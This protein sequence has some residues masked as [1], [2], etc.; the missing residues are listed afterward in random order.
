MKKLFLTII[1]FASQA[2]A[3]PFWPDEAA[4]ECIDLSGDYQCTIRGMQ[5]P[6][7]VSIQQR[8]D[9][10]R[11]SHLNISITAPLE[12]QMQGFS[13]AYDYVT[14]K[15]LQKHGYIGNCSKDGFAFITPIMGTPLTQIVSYAFDP[16]EKNV[17]IDNRLGIMEEGPE[18][19]IANFQVKKDR[20]R[21]TCIKKP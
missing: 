16:R 9:S 20:G 17:K 8:V 11:R 19:G 13:R 15:D 1:L 5:M 14:T 10:E 2:F 3:T 12:S 21:V 18:E 6:L 7:A 4:N